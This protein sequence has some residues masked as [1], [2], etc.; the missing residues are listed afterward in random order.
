MNEHVFIEGLAI[1]TCIGVYDWEREIR[2]TVVLDLELYTDLRAAARSDGLAQTVDYKALSDRLLVLVGEASFELIEALGLAVMNCVLDEFPVQR[3]R[4]R[5]SK[6][7]A[8]P[9]A[10][11]VGVVMEQVRAATATAD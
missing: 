8:V 9:A 2:Q 11:N 3:V 6:P 5:L 4:L 10:R 1:E 7:G